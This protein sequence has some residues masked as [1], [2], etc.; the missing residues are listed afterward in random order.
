LARAG[1]SPADLLP[2]EDADSVQVKP[3]RVVEQRP[4]GD[5]LAAAS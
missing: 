5:P 1:A 2:V 4:P 3:A